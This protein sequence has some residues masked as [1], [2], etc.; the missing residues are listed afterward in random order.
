MTWTGN[1][2]VPIHSSIPSYITLKPWSSTWVTCPTTQTPSY[3]LTFTATLDARMS[4]CTAVRLSC[5][6]RRVIATKHQTVIVMCT[7]LLVEHWP[8]VVIRSVLVSAVMR[9]RRRESRPLGSHSGD[10][11]V[12]NWV[13]LW[14]AVNADVIHNNTMTFIWLSLNWHKPVITSVRLFSDSHS[15]RIR[16]IVDPFLWLKTRTTN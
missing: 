11:W 1:G 13:T 8:S 7:Y 6:G 9:W 3:W 2:F 16:T 14:S 15:L 4:F 10:S 5:R 12:W